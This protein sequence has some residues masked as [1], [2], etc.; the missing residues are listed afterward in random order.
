MIRETCCKS[1]NDNPSSR[2]RKLPGNTDTGTGKEKTKSRPFFLSSFF[3][4]WQK[5]NFPKKKQ[6]KKNQPFHSIIQS[7]LLSSKI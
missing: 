1:N 3:S 2:N 4:P 7:Y 5:K 6:K